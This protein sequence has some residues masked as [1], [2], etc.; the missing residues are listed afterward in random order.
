MSDKKKQTNVTIAC[1]DG[2]KYTGVLKEVSISPLGGLRW[3][4]IKTKKGRIL[5][6]SKYIVSIIYL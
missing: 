1:Q 6:N 2:W 4:E 5:I 3:V